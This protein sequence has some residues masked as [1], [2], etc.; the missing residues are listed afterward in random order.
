MF[1]MVLNSAKLL[2]TGQ[3]FQDKWR[4]MKQILIA[5]VA[6]VVAIFVVDLAA[7]VWVATAIGGAISGFLLP[8]LFKDLK[9]A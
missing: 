4:A 5:V 9:Y 8:I 1:E 7:P 2:L 3:L 6:G